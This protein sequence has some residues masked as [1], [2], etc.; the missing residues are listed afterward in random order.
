M[1]YSF[2]FSWNLWGRIITESLRG[3]TLARIF[4]N[5]A[6]SDIEVTGKILDLGSSSD[7]ASYNRFLK[8]QKPFEIVHTDFYKDGV[9]LLKLDLEK[10]FAILDASFDAITCFN[11]LEH[12]YNFRNLINESHRVLKS[13]GVFV[14]ST[15]FLVNYHA[16]PH[17][18]FRYTHEAIKKMFG[19]AGFV[20]EKMITLSLGPQSAAAFFALQ[21]MPRILRPLFYSLAML[22]DLLIVAIKPSQRMKYPLGY[23]FVFRKS[24]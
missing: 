13:G 18:Y 2:N 21:T 5:H 7:S 10:S 20:C 16:D 12:I 23:V 14:G 19:E 17:D 3:K 15:P 9:G 1:D 4:L 6:L 8:Y 11:T 22:A 24:T